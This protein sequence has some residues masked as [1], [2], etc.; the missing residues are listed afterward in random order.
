MTERVIRF[1]PDDS[2]LGI[3]NVPEHWSQQSPVAVILNAGIVHRAGPFRLHV[4]LA[5]AL[6]DVG[7]AS[8]RMDLSGLGD[9]ETRKVLPEGEDRARL[10]FRD[11]MRALEEVCGA[12]TFVPLGLCSGA[13]NAHQVAIDSGRIV[14]GVFLDGIVY[15]TEGH[16]RRVRKRRMGYRFLRNA[17]KRRVS[18]DLLQ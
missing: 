11:A 5:R 10:D 13:Y 2:L 7:H 8:L 6:S 17:V 16:R 14:G 15:E 18:S 1:G 12:T 4:D 3:L 9:S